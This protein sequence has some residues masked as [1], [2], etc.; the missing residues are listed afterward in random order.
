[1]ASIRNGKSQHTPPSTEALVHFFASAS[2]S[3]PDCWDSPR[4][5]SSGRAELRS[6]S[7]LRGPTAYAAPATC[8]R[9]LNPTARQDH[10]APHGPNGRVD[11][12]FVTYCGRPANEWC[13]RVGDT[14]WP[15]SGDR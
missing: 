5:N 4:S 7:T 9:S 13:P 3:K 15:N 8:A 2:C 11:T 6:S 14:V 10:G 12:V 1:M